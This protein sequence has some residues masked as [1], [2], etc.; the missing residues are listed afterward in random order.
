[1]HPR[2]IKVI[3][4]TI[5]KRMIVEDKFDLHENESVYVREHI[6]MSMV[7]KETCL[8]TYAKGRLLDNRQISTIYILINEEKSYFTCGHFPRNTDRSH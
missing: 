4:E 3:N 6:F 5:F 8:N 1:M 7:F 2:E